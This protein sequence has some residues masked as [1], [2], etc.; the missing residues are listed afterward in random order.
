MTLYPEPLVARTTG[1]SREKVAEAR[2][3]ALVK[4]DDWQLEN[5]VVCYTAPGLKKLLGSLGLA[6]APL[7]WPDASSAPRDPSATPPSGTPDGSAAPAEKSAIALAPAAVAARVSAAGA[8]SAARPLV[9]LLVVSLSRNPTIVHARR[10]EARPV[11]IQD[12]EPRAEPRAELL[13]VRVRTNAN[14]VVGMRLK[15]RAPA[16]GATLYHFEGQ[17]PRWKGRY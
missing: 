12:A 10:A 16:P 5:S 17:C 13:L 14:F 3:S 2:R 4:G 15:A 11:D 9:E 6:D 8:V 1:V 7:A